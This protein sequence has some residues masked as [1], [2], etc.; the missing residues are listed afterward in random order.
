MDIQMRKDGSGKLTITYTIS[1][2]AET[3]GRLDG[4]EKW[5]IIPAGRADWER[6]AARIPGVKLTSYS[7]RENTRA[8]LQ[9]TVVTVSLEYTDAE[10]LVNLIDASGAKVSIS[11][12]NQ[13]NKLSIILNE[14][15]PGEIN[16]DLLDLF[17]SVSA[18]YSVSLSFSADSNSTLKVTDGAGK[19]ISA[20]P[21][22]QVVTSEKKVSFIIETAEVAAMKDGLGMEITW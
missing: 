11:R 9:N 16:T 15:I 8:G 18:G 6:T 4:N 3:I 13:S 10:A 2:M 5:H 22:M 20:S 17:R 7:S 1:N 21:V 12:E 19:E 14:P